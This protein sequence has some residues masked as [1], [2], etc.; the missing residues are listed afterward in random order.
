MSSNLPG[1][2]ASGR[3]K[4]LLMVLEVVTTACL[5][6][7]VLALA[8]ITLMAN[9]TE[10]LR[11]TSVQLEVVIVVVLLLLAVALVSLL[12]LLHTRR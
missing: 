5:L 6:A 3:T 12:A 9:D 11:L 2:D 8:W 7:V 10:S 1:P 4:P